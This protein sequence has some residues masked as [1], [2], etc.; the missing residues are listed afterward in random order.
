VA[1]VFNTPRAV[2]VS[3]YV[4]RAFV[5]LRESI[6]THTERAMRL[7]ELELRWEPKLAP[8]DRAIAGS[9]VAIRQLMTPPESTKALR[10]P[11]DGIIP[12]QSR[13]A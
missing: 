4:M 8:H 11:T 2:E 5:E 12:S 10:L 9:L 6:A 3:L 7:D 1:S 13:H